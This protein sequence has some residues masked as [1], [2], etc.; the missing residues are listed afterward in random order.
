MKPAAD[1]APIYL[2]WNATTPPSQAVRAAM[3]GAAG[4]WANPASVHAL[5]RAARA[6]VESAR[7]RL[8]EVLSVHP[9]D[10]VFTS[11][12]TE[13]N[14]LALHCASLLVTSRLEHPSVVKLAEQLEQS[15]RTRWLPVRADGRV[16]PADI[17]A[18]LVDAPSGTWV[19]VAAANHETGVIH[20]IAEIAAIARGRGA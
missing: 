11:G 1:R 15:G 5:G 4:L 19:S 18:A 7:E 12:G 2:D 20:P 16:D 8:A 3:A 10:V 13:A 17:A 6:V 14:N 9:R